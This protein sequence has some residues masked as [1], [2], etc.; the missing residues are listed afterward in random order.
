MPPAQRYL[1]LYGDPAYGNSHHLISPFSGDG[2]RTDDEKRWNEA[3]AR[4]QIEVKHGFGG[5]V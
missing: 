4:V 5:V 3:M 2:E 1:Q